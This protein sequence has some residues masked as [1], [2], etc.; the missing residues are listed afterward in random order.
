M[1]WVLTLVMKPEAA[2]YTSCRNRNRVDY[3]GGILTRLRLRGGIDGE[4]ISSHE[5]RVSGGGEDWQVKM[6]I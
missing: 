3:F 4:K 2:R 6:A 5:F 1:D